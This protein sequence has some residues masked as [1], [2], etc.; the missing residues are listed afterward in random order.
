MVKRFNIYKE[1]N[2]KTI[3]DLHV[4]FLAPSDMKYIETPKRTFW[5]FI[6]EMIQGT[7]VLDLIKDETVL[8]YL[9]VNFK[10]K[11]NYRH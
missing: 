2:Y 7:N 3:S 11:E 1:G 5:M 8:S 9:W 6:G 10:Y 4:R